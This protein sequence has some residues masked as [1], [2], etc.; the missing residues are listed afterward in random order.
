L[1]HVTSADGTRIACTRTGSGPAL[2]L[3][4]GTTADHHSWSGVTRHFARHFTVYAMDRRGRGESGPVS[5]TDPSREAADVAAV[6]DSI[7]APV[8]VLGHSYGAI[9]AL[10]A[11]RLTGRIRRLVLYEPPIP[12][13]LPMYPAGAPER[14][15]ALIDRGQ[16]E[17]A[18]VFF[19]LEVMLMPADELAAYRR[20]SS[21]QRRIPLAPT[22]PAEIQ[23][24]RTYRFDP[25]AFT[26][27]PT[28]TRLLLGGASPDLYRRAVD[29]V[30]SALPNASVVELPGQRHVAMGT[31]PALFVREVLGFLLT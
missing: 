29:R 23:F 5:Q 6:V 13:G 2:L 16:W 25:A 8:D 28:P 20:R 27:L 7:G 21:W 3:V 19:Y 11:A 12:T 22:I 26:H 10:E 17:D 1:H 24:D 9:C 30:A 15:R 4:H 14:L 18:L 31:H